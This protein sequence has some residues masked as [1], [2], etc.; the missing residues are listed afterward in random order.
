LNKLQQLQ[1]TTRRIWNINIRRMR[2]LLMAIAIDKGFHCE[3]N[4]TFI[5]DRIRSW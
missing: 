1:L 5:F 3:F 4:L 2:P